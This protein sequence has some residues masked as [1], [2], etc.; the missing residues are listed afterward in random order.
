VSTDSRPDA[1]EAVA[2]L[3][4][5]RDDV[6]FLG[7]PTQRSDEQVLRDVTPRI[8]ALVPDADLVI[9]PS[10]DDIN[11]DHVFAYHL[12]LICFRPIERRVN[13]VSMEILSSSEW[14]D[15]PFQPNLYVDISDTVE[16]KAAALARYTKQVLDFPHPR[17]PEAVRIKAQ[18]RGL[19]VGCHS[20]EAFKVVRWFAE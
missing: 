16:L 10:K 14:G 9:V 7:L 12:A 17:S 6:H 18:Q 1:Y 15:T 4:V 11:V 20:A 8:E 2:M 3:G 13:I 5:E 19:E